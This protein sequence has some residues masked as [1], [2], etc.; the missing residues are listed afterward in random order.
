[1]PYRIDQSPDPKRSAPFIVDWRQTIQTILGDV[2]DGVP[3]G[4][5]SVKFHNTLVEAAVSVAKCSGVKQIALTGGCFQN[6][7]LLTRLVKRLKKESLEVIWHRRV[8]T[9]DNG[10]ALGQIMAAARQLR[11]ER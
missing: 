3:V 6:R 5:I 7:Y 8:P 10:I 1:L 11:Q 9:N 4:K 2:Q